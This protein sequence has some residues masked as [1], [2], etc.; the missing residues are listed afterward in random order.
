MDFNAGDASVGLLSKIEFNGVD[1][2][3]ALCQANASIVPTS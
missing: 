2:S 3:T 1:E